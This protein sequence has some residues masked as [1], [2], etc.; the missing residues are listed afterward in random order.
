M[1]WFYDQGK[2]L[3][4]R[5]ILAEYR[6]QMALSLPGEAPTKGYYAS[7]GDFNHFNAYTRRARTGIDSREDPWNE[8]DV[9]VGL[10]TKNKFQIS[11]TGPTRD[12]IIR[13]YSY[14]RLCALAGKYREEFYHWLVTPYIFIDDPKVMDEINTGRAVPKTRAL[15]GRLSGQSAGYASRHP[16][17]LDEHVDRV[18]AWSQPF[19]GDSALSL[20]RRE[21]LHA[22]MTQPEILPDFLEDAG[23]PPDSRLSMDLMNVSRWLAPITETVAAVDEIASRVPLKLTRNVPVKEYL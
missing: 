1:R 23:V 22:V 11:W 7:Q 2:D 13:E 16:R 18:A 9:E 3:P 8:D 10:I 6:R 14:V 5:Q 21:R 15:R 20:S 12:Q 17:D 4:Q 19:Y